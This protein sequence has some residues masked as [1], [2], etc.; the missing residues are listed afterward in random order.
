VNEPWLLVGGSQPPGHFKLRGEIMDESQLEDVES[1]MWGWLVIAE[2]KE[3]T[4]RIILNSIFVRTFDLSRHVAWGVRGA[5]L[6]IRLVRLPYKCR[7]MTSIFGLAFSH[8]SASAEQQIY[9][10]KLKTHHVP[11]RGSDF[12][13]AWIRE[14]FA[15]GR[16]NRKTSAQQDS[17]STI[18]EA[19]PE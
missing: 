10:T 19:L 14:T 16:G 13:H 6:R 3:Q 8:S 15:I 11:P 18:L 17:S 5:R 4:T 7:A 9:S 2:R 12:K 1:E